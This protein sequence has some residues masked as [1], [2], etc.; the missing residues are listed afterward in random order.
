MVAMQGVGRRGWGMLAGAHRVLARSELWKGRDQVGGRFWEGVAATTGRL[1]VAANNIQGEGASAGRPLR[2]W[3]HR[4][5]LAQVR[6]MEGRDQVA[7]RL[8]AWW[9]PQLPK[10]CNSREEGALVGEGRTEQ[11]QML[12]TLEGAMCTV[13]CGWVRKVHRWG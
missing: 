7:G 13:G 6:V 2:G 9:L 10:F 4:L 3:R 8:L 1:W 5:I 12:P 11:A